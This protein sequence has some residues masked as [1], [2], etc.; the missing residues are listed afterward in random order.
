M[1]SCHDCTWRWLLIKWLE[2][3]LKLQWSAD[4]C[5][6][7]TCRAVQ[8]KKKCAKIWLIFT[9]CRS[10]QYLCCAIDLCDDGVFHCSG[11]SCFRPCWTH[12]SVCWPSS[13][14]SHQSWPHPGDKKSTQQPD[15]LTC[16]T[17]Q[18]SSPAITH[19]LLH[20][21]HQQENQYFTVCVVLVVGISV[22]PGWLSKQNI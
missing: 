5:T 9:K 18:H 2:F 13:I 11:F 19:H 16:N 8:S 4:Y 20:L 17:P 3:L 22:N 6:V 15:F 14:S 1:D 12:Q 7:Y 21:T 10:S